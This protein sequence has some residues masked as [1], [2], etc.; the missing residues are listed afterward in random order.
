[1]QLK[2]QQS[3]VVDA[4]L[5]L[6]AGFGTRLGEI[7]KHTPKALL[8][9]NGVPM[10]ERIISQI[11]ESGISNIVI[12]THYLPNK[13]NEF[14]KNY[15][16][17]DPSINFMIS[18]EPEI[19]DTGGGIKQAANLFDL[20]TILITN[21]DG[22]FVENPIPNLLKAWKPEVMDTLLLLQDKD[23][24]IDLKLN[25]DFDIGNKGEILRNKTNSHIFTGS[26]VMKVKDIRNISSHKFHFISDYL[27]PLLPS[28]KIQGLSNKGKWL[29]IGSQDSLKA[30]SNLA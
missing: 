7:T 27:L 8:E 9:V 26:R 5:I 10:L 19:L 13:I 20:N 3:K 29:D 15:S 6:S 1:M 28:N 25:G 4:A 22:F 21:C 18:H 30:A 17:K 2:P 11:K 16:S 14:I 23:K 24:C 12:N